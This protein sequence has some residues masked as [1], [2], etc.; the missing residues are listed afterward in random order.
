[1]GT[2][3]IDSTHI[4]LVL[5]HYISPVLRTVNRFPKCPDHNTSLV[6]EIHIN[7]KVIGVINV[8]AANNARINVLTL[9]QWLMTI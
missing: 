1:M 6:F 7:N 9:C 8:L 2:L 3:R 4:L 5:I